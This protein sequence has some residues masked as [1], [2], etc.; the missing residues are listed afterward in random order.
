MRSR[1]KAGGSKRS[2]NGPSAHTPALEP[3][4]E[5]TS[6]ALASA[7]CQALTRGLHGAWRLVRETVNT[8]CTQSKPT[9]PPSSSLPE[10]IP[11]RDTVPSFWGHYPRLGLT[12][13][14]GH[15]CRQEEGTPLSAWHKGF[16]WAILRFCEEAH[17]FST[18]VDPAQRGSLGPER[19]EWEPLLDSEVAPQG[20]QLLAWEP[21]ATAQAHMQLPGVA[22][23]LTGGG[24]LLKIVKPA[25]Y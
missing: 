23:S 13:G 24:R 7:A 17:S 1:E 5:F 12:S 10:P 4:H 14:P 18:P 19:T 2:L 20:P 25:F 6:M 16:V 11:A 21:D 8:K 22:P 9:P 3:I 15:E